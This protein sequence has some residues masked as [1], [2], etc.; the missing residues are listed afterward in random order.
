ML[1]AS[2]TTLT[3]RHRADYPKVVGVYSNYDYAFAVR[4]PKGV[5]GFNEPAMHPNHGVWVYLDSAETIYLW[6]GAEYNSLFFQSIEEAADSSISWL[7]EDS[8]TGV[9]LVSREYTQLGGLR[10]CRDVVSYKD[11][12]GLPMI[13]ES[14][15]AIRK[16]P[17]DDVGIVYTLDVRTPKGRADHDIEFLESIRK[18]FVLKP[19]PK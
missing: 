9:L 3:N 19:L 18:R 6:V 14:V 5:V 4:L 8:T 10:A 1:S 7:K 13:E 16:D 17:S 11:K 2:T 12:N 15:T